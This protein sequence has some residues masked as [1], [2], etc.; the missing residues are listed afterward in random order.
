MAVFETKKQTKVTL[1]DTIPLKCLVESAEKRED[2]MVTFIFIS[3]IRDIMSL[4][5]L[6][7]D[8]FSSQILKKKFFL[9]FVL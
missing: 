1:D 7:C 5:T 3:D 4:L 8:I 2:H 6:N 9:V